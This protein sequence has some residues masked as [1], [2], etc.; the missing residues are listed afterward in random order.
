[1]KAIGTNNTIVNFQDIHI[2]M[3]KAAE[4]VTKILI[5]EVDASERKFSN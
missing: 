4:K 5:I 3:A 1:M 2:K